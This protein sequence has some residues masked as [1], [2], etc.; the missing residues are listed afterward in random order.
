MKQKFFS[1][2]PLSKCL[3]RLM[4]MFS[5]MVL[6]GTMLLVWGNGRWWEANVSICLFYEEMLLYAPTI[7]LFGIGASLVLDIQIR[8]D[9]HRS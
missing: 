3:F 9:S 2:K 6:A 7:F 1:I 5:G 4:T 8:Q